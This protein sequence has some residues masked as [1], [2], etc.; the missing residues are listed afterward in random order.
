MTKEEVVKS[1]C[2]IALGMLHLCHPHEKGTP[3]LACWSREEGESLEQSQ[4]IPFELNYISQ[5]CAGSSA[6]MSQPQITHGS[7]SLEGSCLKSLCF[8]VGGYIAP[9]QP[10]TR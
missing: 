8:G 5:R 4:G 6:S 10:A 1:A 7:L 3:G 2:E 9:L